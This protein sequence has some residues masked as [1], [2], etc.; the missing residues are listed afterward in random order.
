M[1]AAP[2]G[3]VRSSGA[4]LRLCWRLPFLCSPPCLPCWL[5]WRRAL[6][7]AY[8]RCWG[9][10]LLRKVPTTGPAPPMRHPARATVLLAA[11]VWLLQQCRSVLVGADGGSL[12][13]QGGMHDQFPPGPGTHDQLS[14]GRSALI[15]QEAVHLAALTSHQLLAA[16]R[17][18]ALTASMLAAAGGDGDG[19]GDGGGGGSSQ[20]D[21]RCSY[22]CVLTPTCVTMPIGA[23]ASRIVQERSKRH[24]RGGAGPSHCHG[25][26]DE[27]GA[28]RPAAQQGGASGLTTSAEGICV[29]FA[30]VPCALL[31]PPAPAPGKGPGADGHSGGGSSSGS[32]QPPILVDGVE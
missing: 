28:A 2:A 5:L 4:A 11:R 16:L 7:A 6:R 27:E 32:G 22:A 9:C 19:G 26:A 29:S 1:A 14:D 13:V 20:Q 31:A 8:S 3:A 15:A 24:G 23:D 21:V 25:E 17:L 18:L 12:L 30:R 10:S